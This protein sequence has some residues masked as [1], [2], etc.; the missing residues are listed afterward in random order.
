MLYLRNNVNIEFDYAEYE[1]FKS[2]KNSR[3]KANKSFITVIDLGQLGNVEIPHRDIYKIEELKS[4]LL[5]KAV[6]EMKLRSQRFILVYC[7]EPGN[8]VLPHRHKVIEFNENH[9]QPVIGLSPSNKING[10]VIEDQEFDLTGHNHILLNVKMLH[11]V[12]AQD[13]PVM[14]ITTFGGY[15]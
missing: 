6:T 10:L 4:N 11:S 13:E 1:Y 8:A 15:L 14:W 12:K 5:S 2:L 7:S 3:N 9:Y